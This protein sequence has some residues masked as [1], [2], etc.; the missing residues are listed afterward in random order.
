MTTG[1]E[2]TL[3]TEELSPRKKVEAEPCRCVNC[4]ECRGSGS[5]WFAFGG[6]EYLGN[7]RCDDLD[8]LETCEGC[9]GSGI[10]ET[11][12]RCQLLEEMDY[13]EFYP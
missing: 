13:D 10:V 5:V 2:P 1:T 12:D 7:S 9:G 8:E 6:K 4:G 3:T 11:C